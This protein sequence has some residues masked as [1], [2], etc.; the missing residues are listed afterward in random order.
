MTDRIVTVKS[1]GGDYT[2]V[3]A[4]ISGEVADLVTL[5]TVL[6]INVYA[7]SDTTPIDSGQ[8]YVTDGTYNCKLTVLEGECHTGE[9]DSSKYN[10]VTSN[11]TYWSINFDYGF[12]VYATGI[13]VQSTGVPSYPMLTVR[14]NSYAWMDRMIIVGN[15]LTGNCG[16]Q[17]EGVNIASGAAHLYNSIIYGFNY[18]GAV[19]CAGNVTYVGCTVDGGDHCFEN[20]TFQGGIF[21]CIAFNAVT[22]CFGGGN[23]FGAGNISDDTSY[24]SGTYGTRVSQT[25]TFVDAAGHDYRLASNDAGALG[26]GLNVHHLDNYFNTPDISIDAAGNERGHYGAV[27]DAGALE[28][29]PTPIL[30]GTTCWGHETDVT[31]ANVLTFSG[32]WSGTGTIENSGDSERIRVDNG[33]YM[34]SEMANCSGGIE[35]TLSKDKY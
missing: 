20:I 9:W 17:Y 12:E 33:E 1:T 19:C 32:R 35:V 16:W 15:G 31:E 25:L 28:Y 18:D 23:Y 4:A 10:L 29:F 8:A 6:Y 11:T 7:F 21:N 26:Y 34:I 30:A 3:N 2:S 5:T 13:Q 22:S 14:I 27:W 24:P